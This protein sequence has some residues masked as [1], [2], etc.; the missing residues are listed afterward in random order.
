MWAVLTAIGKAVYWVIKTAWAYP[1]ISAGIAAAASLG[2]SLMRKD[3]ERTWI[4]ETF[5]GLLD[6]VSVILA[7]TAAV[8]WIY[9]AAGET[10]QAAVQ[11]LFPGG[12]SGDPSHFQPLMKMTQGL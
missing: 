9:S 12:G 3:N 1:Y 5:I 7:A 8:R 11:W 10:G 6:T 2:A 4:E